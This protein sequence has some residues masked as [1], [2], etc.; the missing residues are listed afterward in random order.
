MTLPWPSTY[1]IS[2]GPWN[3]YSRLPLQPQPL[4]PSIVCL[5]ESHHQQ[6]WGLHLHLKTQKIPSG[7]KDTDSSHPHHSGYPHTDASC[8]QPHQVTPAASFML[9]TPLLQPTMLKTPGAASMYMFPPRVI[10]AAL[11]DKLLPLQ[12]KMNATLEQ[13]L[14]V[15]SS[16][17]LFTTKSWT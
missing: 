2:M 5:G 4:S 8:R 10:P 12:Q 15:R 6:P 14:T 1:I 7:P 3:G 9:L 17:D 11:L 13:L 16:R